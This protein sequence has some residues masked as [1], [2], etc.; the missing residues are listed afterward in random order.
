MQLPLETTS[1]GWLLTALSSLASLLA[2]GWLFKLYNAY[3]ARR[4]IAAQ[5]TEITVR[6]TATAGDSIIRMMDRLQSAQDDI[7][8]LRRERNEWQE[9]AEKSDIDVRLQMRQVE[10][11][12]SLLKLHNID[13]SEFDHRPLEL[14]DD[15]ND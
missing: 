5:T 12:L 2:G 15:A 4:K 14:S 13:Y 11:L 7:D 8:R 10:R 6:T 1:P 3:A 9:Q